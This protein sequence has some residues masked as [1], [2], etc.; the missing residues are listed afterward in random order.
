MS[1][2]RALAAG[3]RIEFTLEEDLSL[4]VERGRRRDRDDSD[5]ISRR[6]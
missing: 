2:I 1:K 3:H 5:D 4:D 6:Y